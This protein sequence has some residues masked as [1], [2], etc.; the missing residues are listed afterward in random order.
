M[1]CSVGKLVRVGLRLVL[2]ARNLTLNSDA[3]PNHKYVSGPY[4]GALLR[5]RNTNYLFRVGNSGLSPAHPNVFMLTVS[6]II[7]I[8]VRISVSANTVD[9]RYLDLAYLE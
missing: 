5:L 6:S 8:L 2:L 7:I 3:A 9:S 1:E 4:K